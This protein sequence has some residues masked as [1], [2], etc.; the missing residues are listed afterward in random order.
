[1]GGRGG[2][3]PNGLL[4]EINVTPLVDV[5]LVL[6]VIMMV[7]ATAVAN[8]TIAVE[9]PRAASGT[10]S[11]KRAPLVVTI[12]EGGALYVD[13]KPVTDRD[14]RDRASGARDSA[15]V[16]ADARARHASVV[17]VLDLLRSERVSRIAIVVKDAPR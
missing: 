10:P 8:K 5:V 9:L 11:E 12:D 16:A 4:A 6:L 7:T 15:V 3:D 17:H 14:V 1:M 13:D 2:T